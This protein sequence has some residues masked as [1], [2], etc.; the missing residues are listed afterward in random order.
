MGKN[1]LAPRPSSQSTVETNHIVL[2]S[3][4]NALGTIFGG[5][6]MSWIDIAAAICAQ[7]HSGSIAVTA[8]VDALYFLG[9]AK[10]GDTV[11]LKARV[12]HTGTTSMV[13]SVD[14]VAENPITEKHQRCVEAHL[15]FVA[16]N[17]KHKPTPVPPLL[18]ETKED[19]RLFDRAAKRRK[20]LLQQ[21]KEVL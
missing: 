3:H 19:K 15:S 7:R 9:P 18:L 13:V 1:R 4:A 12:I 2:P 8:S 6:L 5:V 20:I 11:T 21:L 16:L 14:V 10:V 17:Q